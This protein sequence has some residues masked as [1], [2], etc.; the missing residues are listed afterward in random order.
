MRNVTFASDRA[1]RK[2]FIIASLSQYF[3]FR[4]INDSDKN[5][6]FQEG[7]CFRDGNYTPNQLFTFGFTRSTSTNRYE[8][9]A[10]KN[11]PSTALREKWASIFFFFFFFSNN[12]IQFST[13]KLPKVIAGYCRE[14]S[15]NDK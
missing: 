5:F 11:Q 8:V 2:P 10:C 15:K 7:T 4:K 14:D 12:T 3:S 6:I 13:A 9:H 1:N